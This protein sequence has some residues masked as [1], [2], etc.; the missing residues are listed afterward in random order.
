MDESKEVSEETLG[1]TKKEF[2][3]KF[4]VWI[5]WV[6]LVIAIAVLVF[7]GRLGEDIFSQSLNSF[8]IISIVYIGG[9]VTQKVGKYASDAVADY[10]LNKKKEGEK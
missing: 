1:T 3:R 4:F 10:I 2:G 7:L 5:V 6:I 9:N 8:Y